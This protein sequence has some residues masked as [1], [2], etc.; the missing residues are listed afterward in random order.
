MRTFSRDG[1]GRAHA[2][3]EAITGATAEAA[4]GIRDNGS[5]TEEGPVADLVADN[6]LQLAELSCFLSAMAPAVYAQSN[7]EDAAIGQHVRNI[8]DHY[9]CLLGAPDGRVDYTRR[10]REEIIGSCPEAA[11][12]RIDATRQR[13]ARLREITGDP[14]ESK[15]E[16][17]R[18][19]VIFTPA[20][21]DR[22]PVQRRL[23]STLERE[24]M[25]VLSHTIHHMALIAV[26]V[27]REGTVPIP[28]G[29]GVAPSTMRYA[30]Q[31]RP[32]ACAQ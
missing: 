31:R 12:S 9:E 20:R 28:S 32:P 22:E 4:A 29:F 3:A 23:T 11:I 25:F 5:T 26:L 30:D 2:G 6:D 24:L 27:R 16:G 21:T 19:E 10:A 17:L 7:G 18:M 13:I 1:K 14:V 15:G 8:L